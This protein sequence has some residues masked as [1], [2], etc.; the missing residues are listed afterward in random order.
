MAH[1]ESHE[2]IPTEDEDL[3][4]AFMEMREM[5]KLL[6]KKGIQ[7]C[8]VKAPTLQNT[9]ETV[10]IKLQMEMEGMVL[11]HHPHLHLLLLLLP[12]QDLFQILKKDMVNSFKNSFVK[13]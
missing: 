1:E 9:R 4:K 6:M 13:A 5:M 7:G 11:L 12:V 3:R 8:K 2:H 10:V